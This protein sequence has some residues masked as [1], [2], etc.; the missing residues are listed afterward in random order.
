MARRDGDD[1]EVVGNGRDLETRASE[2]HA[3]S[4]VVDSDFI[5]RVYVYGRRI[6]QAGADGL[7]GRYDQVQQWYIHSKE[8]KEEKGGGSPRNCDV[9]FGDEFSVGQIV[10]WFNQG[11]RGQEK[12]SFNRMV[13]TGRK[14][15]RRTGSF[16]LPDHDD[17]CRRRKGHVSLGPM[18]FLPV[19][20]R[21]V[22]GSWAIE[23]RLGA[24]TTDTLVLGLGEATMYRTAL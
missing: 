13:G 8:R 3:R 15:G 6:N 1:G 14:I 12:N 18:V 23:P 5:V 4:D 22:R 20:T 7:G 17:I 21:L 19:R 24:D 16:I 9:K 10:L 2:A 11:S